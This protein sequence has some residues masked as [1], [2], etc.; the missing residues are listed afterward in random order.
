MNR[1][2]DATAGQVRNA[3]HCSNESITGAVN[4]LDDCLRA[5][6]VTDNGAQGADTNRERI[7]G[8]DAAAP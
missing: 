2:P 8:N 3:F 1:L 4:C 7:V 6:R 5:C